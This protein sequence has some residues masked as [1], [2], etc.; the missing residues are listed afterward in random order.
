MKALL[1]I[2]T[3]SGAI[4]CVLLMATAVAAQTA[5]TPDP[6]SATNAG[7]AASRDTSERPST[8]GSAAPGTDIV[9]TGSRI[10]QPGLVSS[11]PIVSVGAA[12]F[13]QTGAVTLEDTL[14]RLP[15]LVPGR[16]AT[17]NDGLTGGITTLDL[18]GLGS[19]RTLVLM[20]SRRLQASTPLGSVDINNIPTAL[21]EN[22][23]VVTGGASAA[24][25]SDAIAGVV[26]FKLNHRF[27]GV[28]LDAQNGITS[29]GDGFQTQLSLTAGGAFSED[30]GHA[31]ISISYAKRDG[32]GNA[33]RDFS[34]VVR[35]SSSLSTGAYVSNAGNLPSQ[36][37]VNSVFAGYGIAAGIVPRTGNLS[38]NG[39]GSLFTYQSS[40]LNYRGGGSDLLVGPAS[41]RYNSSGVNGLTIP[42]ERLGAYA[43]TDYDI[44]ESINV[45]GE[46]NFAHFTSSARYAPGFTTV[47]VPVTNPFIP[48]ALRTVLASRANPNAN[49]SVTRRF[50]EVGFRE[51]ETTT[52]NFQVRIGAK[53]AL[54]IR[55]WTWD[56]YGSYGRSDQ[57]ERDRNGFSSSA[58]QSLVSA[59][60]GGAS[61]CAGGLSLFGPQANTAC[62]NYI[63]R[64]TLR[65][66][67]S[68]QKVAEGT[69]Q[70]SLFSLPAGDVRFA[71][72]VDYRSDRFS[73][74]PDAA[75]QSGDVVS[76]SSGGVPPVSGTI[77]AKE[78]Y[79]ELSVP[80]L[81]DLPGIKKLTAGAG[82]RYS[83]YNTSGSV[84]SFRFDG[85]W[86]V[87]DAFRIR[88]GFSRAVRAPSVQELFAP[89]SQTSPTI[90][91]AG[92]TGQ[93]DPCDIRSAYRTGSNAAAVRSLCLAQGVPA[94]IIDSYT[95]NSVQITDGGVT[96]GN[97]NLSPEKANTYTV[98]AV[99]APKFN[100]PWISAFSLS[101][102]Y[103]NI[104]LSKAVG[105]VSGA[106]AIQRCYN[107]GGTNSAYA[108]SNVYCGLFGRSS[109]TGEI[110][111]IALNNLN[112]GVVKTSGLDV[113][114][115]WT[116]NLADAGAPGGGSLRLG[117][118]VNRLFHYLVQTLPGEAETDYVGSAGYSDQTSVKALPRWKAVANVAYSNGPATIG[119]Q[120]RYIGPMLDVSVIG[121]SD[122]DGARIPS[123]SYFDINLA[124]KA[125]NRFDFRLGVN[126]LTDKKPPTLSSFDQSNTLPAVYD[127]FG[128]SF[129]VGVTS[130][131]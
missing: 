14:N 13:R 12:A 107:L 7:Q 21:I 23:E 39:D 67:E 57:T 65:S 31:Q 45:Y 30:R 20:D 85:N 71:A 126:N 25:G 10:A 55:D 121:T 93:G 109:S 16:G 100:T 116:L 72:G 37:A 104:R 131:F 97:I 128:R 74:D 118:S 59:A 48:A 22:V 110:N 17:S 76:F 92:T 33:A 63:R 34:Q 28:Q 108:T 51:A 122:T 47:S 50:A 40:A 96:G 53:G 19:N 115:D 82:Y 78:A 89:T 119:V 9:V 44:T 3:S 5:A 54:G 101:V 81:A 114:A 2:G 49:F 62:A 36:A 123:R 42:Y 105:V 113:A 70:G 6:V 4:G 73:F 77:T 27:T 61:L 46:F 87:I 66:S 52:N 56:L 64:N 80:L 69:I 106:T 129:Y 41:I 68:D 94:N 75:L 103:Y 43:H 98:G 112:L 60:D 125:S 79:G 99:L 120:Y 102:D 11:S 1:R 35:P 91:T 38:F 29:R 26:N 8:D 117:G 32:I 24:Y 18:R 95:F 84:Q 58:L 130:R 86:E 88:G 111:S 83:D 127:V 90:G 15:Q 124:L